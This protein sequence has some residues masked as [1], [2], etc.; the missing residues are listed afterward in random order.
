MIKWCMSLIGAFLMLSVFNAAAA[1]EYALGAGDVI[2]VQVF[3]NPDLTTEAR[4]SESGDISFPLLGSVNVGGAGIAQAERKIADGLVRGGFVQKPQ[5]NIVLLQVRGNQVAVLG[6]VGRPGRFVI[7]TFD[8]HLSEMLAT[9]GGVLN[10]AGS[11]K[12][13]LTGVRDGNTFRKEIDLAEVFLQDKK[14][15]DILLMR[16]DVIY[17]IPGNQISILGQVNRPGRYPLENATMKFSD[18]IAM[19]GGVSSSGDDVAIVQ[20]TRDGQPFSKKVDLASI[21]LDEDAPVNL[22]LMAGDSVYVHR[23]GTFY[24]YGETQRPGSYRVERNMT[25]RQALAQ[26][27]GPTA[28]GTQRGITLQR[29]A[30]SGVVEKSCPGLDDLIQPGDVLY[31]KESL[32]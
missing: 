22:D 28:R 8:T 19:A 13:I 27:G 24:I 16:G 11:G 21:Y 20:G 5:V 3:Q 30:A 15:S 26:G 9:A 25:V 6:A 7:E 2:R 10:G 14:E 12:A 1:E 23:A 4:V 32:F 17:V 31:V 18:A 29:R